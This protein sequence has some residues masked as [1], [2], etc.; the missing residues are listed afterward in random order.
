MKNITIVLRRRSMLESTQVKDDLDEG[1]CMTST[2]KRARMLLCV[3]CIAAF[4]LTMG[5]FAGHYIPGQPDSPASQTL[6]TREVSVVGDRS[7]V[8]VDTVVETAFGDT[9]DLAGVTQG[10]AY[11]RDD[12]DEDEWAMI[13]DEV[14]PFVEASLPLLSV[15]KNSEE[16][17]WPR[18]LRVASDLPTFSMKVTGARTVSSASFAEFY[19]AYLSSFDYDP[20]KT[21]M[22]VNVEASNPS[23]ETVATIP[24]LSLRYSDDASDASVSQSETGMGKHLLG[25]LYPANPEDVGITCNA[26]DESWSALAPGET[27]ELTLPFLVASAQPELSNWCIQIFDYNPI[28]CYRF[29]LAP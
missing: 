2:A 26:L 14:K 27:R 11:S 19:P 5:W 20:G 15:Q 28:I 17:P 29:L 18:Y 21:V 8:I 3:C 6:G 13:P 1:D 12:F 16:G 25:A 22:L 10:K 7:E 24:I 4:L 23:L 9:L